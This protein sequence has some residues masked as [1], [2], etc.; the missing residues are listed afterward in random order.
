MEVEAVVLSVGRSAWL[1]AVRSEFHAPF[2]PHIRFHT[3]DSFSSFPPP[4]A[5]RMRSSVR[6]HLRA[7]WVKGGE[8][9]IN[10]IH[11]SPTRI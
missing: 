3:I 4:V 2:L 7:L 1:F 6:E 11:I 5:C 9:G 10:F 8:I